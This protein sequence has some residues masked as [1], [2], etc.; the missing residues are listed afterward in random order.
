M[1]ISNSVVFDVLY[2]K[3]FGAH[4]SMAGFAILD[5]VYYYTIA[6]NET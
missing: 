6:T 5:L 3:R 4:I 2:D 1:Y